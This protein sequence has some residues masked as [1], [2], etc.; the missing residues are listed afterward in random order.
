MLDVL[1][2]VP[3][4]R[5]SAY[6]PLGLLAAVEPP[7]WAGM[8]AAALRKQGYGVA[9]LD[10]EAEHLPAGQI[11]SAV[12]TAAPRL[13]CV[14]AYGH[15]P[16]ASTQT[17]P[18]ARAALQAIRE[19]TQIP[20]AILGGHVSALPERTLREEPVDFVIEGEGPG[21]LGPLIE[22]LKAGG[23]FSKV[24]GLWFRDP[25]APDDICRPSSHAPLLQHLDRDLPA[26][27]WD[28]LLMGRYRAHGWHCLGGSLRQP[29]AALYTSLGCPYRCEFCMIQAPFKAGESALG[30]DADVNTYRMWSPAYIGEQIELLATKYGVRNIKIVDEMFWLNRNHVEGICDE[31]LRRGLGDQL[32]LW[33][34]ARVDTVR[35]PTLLEKARC[36]G[37]QWLALGIEAAD[38]TVR[39]GQ[40]KDFSDEQIVKTV[41][42]IQA[43]GINVIG[44]YIFGLPGDTKDSMQRTLDLALELQCEWANFYPAMAFPGSHLYEQAVAK[45]LRLPKSW[46]GY[47]PL[48]YECVPLPTEVLSS[49]E[50]LAFRDKAF[51][52]Y[53]TDLSWQWS[54]K[55]KFNYEVLREIDQMVATPIR[56]K[57]LG[58]Q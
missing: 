45:G 20:T 7:V 58:H 18:G 13:A 50:I 10:A 25:H 22:A 26:L 35:W 53:F 8:L 37:F 36:A 32:N 14:V 54:M 30:F 49:E 41:R 46:A 34:Y 24:P 33:A 51:L 40:D 29:Y 28:L 12:W 48:G 44:N 43:A 9:I 6:G 1:F 3:H 17:M 55:V 31:I 39:D 15:Q 23:G 19:I 16:S 57:I 2:V 4:S 52:R 27:A 38:S 5:D 47:A 21:T 56:R 42:A 11:A